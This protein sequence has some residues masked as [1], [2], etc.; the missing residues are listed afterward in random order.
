MIRTNQ[1]KNI[2]GDQKLGIVKFFYWMIIAFINNLLNSKITLSETKILKFK[3]KKNSNSLI[4]LCPSPSRYWCDLFW[5]SLPFKIIFKSGINALEVGCGSGTYGFFLKKNSNFKNYTGIDIQINDNWRKHAEPKMKFYKNTCYNVVKYLKN[6]NFLFTQSALEHFEYDLR[7]HKIVSK[8]LRKR[9]K[10]FFQL[11]L[12]PSDQCL[13]TYLAHGYRHFNLGS[14]SKIKEIYK[15]NT[16]TSFVL[17]E[18]GSYHS[19]Y[20]HFKFITIPQFIKFLPS[21]EN[22]K[23]IYKKFLFNAVK[24]DSKQNIYNKNKVSFY[25]LMIFSNYSKNQIKKIINKYS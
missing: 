21:R 10:S 13:F 17:F 11:H 23:E 7:F 4:N 6:I 5:R 1:I 14:V 24:K 8:F 3:P 2:S 15:K 12:I 9:K 19:W 18:L 22:N 20:L 25:A 16:N